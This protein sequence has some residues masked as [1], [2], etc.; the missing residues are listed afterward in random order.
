MAAIGR[1]GTRSLPAL[2][3]GAVDAIITAVGR[4]T[5]PCSIVNWDHFHGPATRI[6]A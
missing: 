5:S 6:P 3:P 2:T 1:S 4:K